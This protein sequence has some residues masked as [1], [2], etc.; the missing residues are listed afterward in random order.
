MKLK[1]SLLLFLLIGI[2]VVEWGCDDE[3]SWEK[4]LKEH[5]YLIHGISQIGFYHINTDKE[6]PDSNIW[7]SFYI[8]AQLQSHKLG[9][10]GHHSSSTSLFASQ[11]PEPA[12]IMWD[13]DSIFIY[14]YLVDPKTDIKHQFHFASKPRGEFSAYTISDLQQ[15]LRSN[16][17]FSDFGFDFKLIDEPQESAWHRYK[18]EIYG[19]NNTHFTAVSDSLFIEK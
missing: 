15:D 7:N 13:I 17:I 3:S 5:S 8:K 4:M 2:A 19:T 12:N 18:F 11:S 10:M 9:N 16:H 1:T 14:D 6:L